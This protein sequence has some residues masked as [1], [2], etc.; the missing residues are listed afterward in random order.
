VKGEITRSGIATVALGAALL[1]G[2][3]LDVPKAGGTRSAVPIPAL[4]G[5]TPLST[6]DFDG[7]G[8]D[9][10]AVGVPREDVAGK[11]DAGAVA[12]LYGSPSGLRAER[13][14]LWTQGS[15]GVPGAL[16]Q[17]DGFGWATT[18]GDFDGDGYDDLAIG[19]PLEGYEFKKRTANGCCILVSSPG[20][21]AVNVLY[22]SRNGLS[23]ARAQVWHQ[24][25]PGIKGE[26]EEGNFMGAVLAAGDFNGD[27]RDELAVGV[28]GEN[29]GAGAVQIL[30]GTRSGLGAK[31]DQLW[32]Q[33]RSNV[34]DVSERGDSFGSALAAGNLGYSSRE[35]DL[36]IG[37]PGED[38]E[39]VK[40]AGAVQIL[41]GQPG[42]GLSATLVPDLFL[43]QNGGGVDDVAEA[44]DMFGAALAIGNFGRTAQSD[45]AVGVPGESVAVARQGA[46]QVFYGSSFGVSVEDEQLWRVGAGSLKGEPGAAHELGRSLAAADFNGFSQDDLAIGSPYAAVDGV[47]GAGAVHIVYGGPAG[48]TVSGSV[49][50]PDQIWTRATLP[51]ALLAIPVGSDLFGFALAGGRFGR[52]P[53]GADLAASAPNAAGRDGSGANCC[54]ASGLVH[55]LAGGGPGGLSTSNHRVWHQNMPGIV[56]ESEVGDRFGGG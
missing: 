44:R 29:K 47:P 49:A 53:A 10:L 31:D 54:A 32:L 50:V 24:G 6:G 45:L 34:D 37:I 40:D 15:S 38:V 17:N 46:A 39:T 14:Q 51:N 42:K 33:D 5:P 55:V 19:A 13:N 7:D 43:H 28:P 3:A 41:Y 35:E 52:S 21:G 20:A 2:V 27:A 36:A 25:T 26:P 18:T 11:A 48:L 4:V 1:A 9:D 22:G 23:A 30:V 12:V 56:D 8:R 16:E